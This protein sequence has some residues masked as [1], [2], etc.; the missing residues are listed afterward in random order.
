MSERQARLQRKSEPE[1]NKDQKKGSVLANIIITVIILAFLGL[2][3]YA[4]KD[5]IKALIPEKPE[6]EA[7]VSDMAKERDMSVD[8]FITEFGLDAEQITKDS[9]EQDLMSQ[10]TV[11]N[12]AKYED[13]SIDEL[14][15]EYGI[16]GIDENMLWQDA[17]Q[18]MPMSK[19]A[20]MM[21]TTFDEMKAQSGLPEGVT[22]STTLKQA[23]EIMAAQEPEQTEEQPA[24]TEETETAENAE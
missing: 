15:D 11:A 9:T 3:G 2:G 17:V 7:T 23:Q 10:F 4:L 18:L 6:K 19:Y 5:K 14:L 16:E 20:E 22:E 12:Y 1:K 21:G 8:E 24:Q 13:K